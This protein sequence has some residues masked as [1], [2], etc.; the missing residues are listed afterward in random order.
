MTEQSQTAIS[1]VVIEDNH[2][3]AQL[4]GDILQI[5]G[6]VPYIAHN[7]IA[8][9]NLSKRIL[10]SI[11][12]CDLGLPGEMNGL[13]FAQA[14]RREARLSHTPLVAITGYTSEHDKTAAINAGFNMI[15]P[16][17]FKFADL[18]QALDRYVPKPS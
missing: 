6:C 9:M 11:I 14:L 7:A 16:K 17:P 8:G 12:F 5:Q 2:D 18:R 13:E 1:V 4:I 3:F 10:P 15:F